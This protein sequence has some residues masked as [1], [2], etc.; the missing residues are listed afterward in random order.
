[1]NSG[2]IIITPFYENSH[3]VE[4]I[5]QSLIKNCKE[6]I[7]QQATVFLINDSPYD[8]ALR[9]QIEIWVGILRD[10]SLDVIFVEN[11]ANLGFIKSCNKGL[12][13]A[14]A[15]GRHAL[16][17]NSDTKV[18]PGFLNEM[19]KVMRT[20]PMVGFVCPRSNNATLCTFPVGR[21]A[22]SLPS[23]AAYDIF[24]QYSKFIPEASY[25]PTGV[26]FCLL[27]ANNILADFGILDDVYGRGYN[28]ENDIIMRAGRC[29]YRVALANRAFVWHEG[30]Q[31]FSASSTPKR[32]VEGANRK[33]LNQRY[34]EYTGLLERYARSAQVEAERLVSQLPTQ[35]DP[36]CFSV[37][38]DFSTFGT[39][40][41]GTFEAGKRILE[42]ACRVWP[43][44]IKIIVSM[45][46]DAF[47]F[48]GLDKIR[49]IKRCNPGSRDVTSAVVRF[50]QI[51]DTKTFF[52]VFNR[53]PVVLNFMLDTIAHD[54]SGLSMGLNP[55][56]WDMTCAL[57]DVLLT[58]SEFTAKQIRS[59]FHVPAEVQ[60]RA[61][62]H[63]TCPSDYAAT[64]QRRQT[65]TD[66]AILIVGNLFPHKYVL[67]TVSRITAEFPDQRFL[68]FGVKDG[69][70]ASN[71][72]YVASGALSDEE[73]TSLY[74]HARMIVFPSHYEGFGFP[75]MHGIAHGTPVLARNLPVYQEIIESIHPRPDI[76][77]FQNLEDLVFKIRH[78]LS[79]D[80]SAASITTQVYDGRDWTAS[81][82]ELHEILAQQFLR[83]DSK[84]LAHRLTTISAIASINLNPAPHMKEIK[85]KVVNSEG[86]FGVVAQKLKKLNRDRLYR[87]K[88]RRLNKQLKASA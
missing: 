83:F 65:S 74:R 36:S 69:P 13:L 33:I 66:A 64:A 19:L 45:N 21:N 81:A 22:E 28:E 77:F 88:M 80:C 54:C 55:S 60:M 76:Q 35:G 25:A 68:C 16:L 3:L 30:E 51:F 41:N 61:L 38:F 58:N 79:M 40:H 12:T 29:G 52:G 67:E 14:K 10:C 47:Q 34:P 56:L 43:D 63:S 27:I 46:A 85:E 70:V 8:A 82:V 50:G 86:F 7:D 72:K 53:A 84:R 59:R 4:Q 2:P 73:T 15:S 42:A 87:R 31:S 75:L 78:S 5:S 57:S 37:T 1:M 71:V 62:L 23:D 44:T 39:Y 20:D 6:L 48:H 11:D 18:F 32:Q 9:E 17:L 49:T 24:K 26:G